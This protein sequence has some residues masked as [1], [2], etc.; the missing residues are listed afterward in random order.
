[1]LLLHVRFAAYTNEKIAPQSREMLQTFCMVGGTILPS[2]PP[3]IQIGKFSQLC[4]PISCQL[5]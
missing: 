3:P 5:N 1:M 4:E 2:P